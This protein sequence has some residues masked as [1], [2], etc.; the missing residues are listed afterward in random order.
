[1]KTTPRFV[2]TALALAASATLALGPASWGDAH[3]AP[4]SWTGQGTSGFWCDAL[5]GSPPGAPADGDDLLFSGAPPRT[6]SVF[7]LARS[8]S[9][10]TFSGDSSLF[11]TQVLGGGAQLALSGLGIRAF[12]TPGTGI[13]RRI[14]FADAGSTGGTILF[15]HSS[16][17]NV[18]SGQFARAVDITARGGSTAGAI[19]G[20][21]VFQDRSSTSASTFDALRAEGASVAGATGG[22]IIVR[23]NALVTRMTGVVVGGGAS[24]G[25]SRGAGGRAFRA[26]GADRRR[27]V[28]PGRAVGGPGRAHRIRRQHGVPRHLEHLCRG[29][30]F[31][32]GW[33]RGGDELSR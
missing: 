10:L 13:G 20:H 29:W 17:V 24:A 31:R 2:R 18:G 28:C 15:T 27:R 33:L 11:V 5:N 14:F 1:M 8:F 4:V 12:D 3:A 6:S 22:E 7:D 26:R 21:V 19:G 23:D 30:Q 25:A 16:G 9:S 32:A